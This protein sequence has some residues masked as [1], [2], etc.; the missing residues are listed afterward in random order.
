LPNNCKHGYDVKDNVLRITVHRSPTE[1]DPTADQGTHE[2]TYSLLLHAGPWRESEVIQDAYALND[3]LIPRSIPANLQGSLLP[4]YASAEVDTDYIILETVK[5]GE[6]VEL[7]VGSS[8][9]PNMQRCSR[10]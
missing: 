6:W 1:P 2:F 8:L 10:L 9:Q 4:V 5:K 3:R 7:V